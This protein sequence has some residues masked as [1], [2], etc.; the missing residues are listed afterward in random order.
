MFFYNKPHH[1]PQS[2]KRYGCRNLFLEIKNSC[3]SENRI[4]RYVRDLL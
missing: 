3:A 4:S 2:E 1:D